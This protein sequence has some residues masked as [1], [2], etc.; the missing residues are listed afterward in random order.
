MKSVTLIVIVLLSVITTKGFT[1]E[2]SKKQIKEEE[3]IEKQ[4]QTEVLMNSK[5]FVF[6]AKSAMPSG[7]GSINLVNSTYNIVFQ[8]EYFISYL[9]F[10]GTVYNG[11][12][13]GGD[14]G[15]KFKGKPEE[16]TITKGKKN[17][18]INAVLKEDNDVY[19]ISLSV[20]PTGG[21]I[22]SINSNHRSSI[23]YSGDIMS[24]EA[25]KNS[26]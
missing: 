17:Y 19:Q 14:N 4:K 13:P 3:K 9:P 16:F 22:L 7:S 21:A 20:N 11:I 24:I 8:P 26:K 23:S 5:K 12:G 18:N 2:K 15:Y 6:K 10:Y 25:A 1:Q